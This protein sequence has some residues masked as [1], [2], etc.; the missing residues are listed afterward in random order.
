M[1]PIPF[2]LATLMRL[3]Q[4]QGQPG[5]GN[6]GLGMGMPSAPPPAPSLGNVP[7]R[8]VRLLLRWP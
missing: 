4:Q 8:W 1:P 5:M 6:D 3:A 7:P 2:D